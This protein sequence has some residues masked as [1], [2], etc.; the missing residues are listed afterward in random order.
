MPFNNFAIKYS[1]RKTL[2]LYVFSHGVEV[3]APSGTPRSVINEFV[4]KRQEWILKHTESLQLKNNERY[5][6]IHGAKIPLLGKPKELI[7]KPAHSNR[8]KE[9]HCTIILEVTKNDQ[10]VVEQV[11][12]K[13]LLSKAQQH[14]PELTKQLA[15]DIGLDHHLTGVVFRR[16]KTKWGHCTS[17]GR[18]QY[19]WLIMMAPENIIYSLVAHEVAHLAHMNHSKEF[20]ALVAKL[21]P[22]Y[23]THKKWLTEHGH[24]F[25]VFK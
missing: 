6:L 20:W 9:T 5:Q 4:N 8:A 3:R 1:Q 10:S 21:D 14:L 17:K 22:N 18:I 11:F 25:D 13:L 12:R 24:R 7:I 23:K 15:S 19:N 16:T 2:G